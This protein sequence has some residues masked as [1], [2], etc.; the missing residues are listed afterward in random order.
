MD[1]YPDSQIEAYKQLVDQIDQV[2]QKRSIKRSIEFVSNGM[3]T[4]YDRVIDLLK[5]TN[6]MFSISYDPVGRYMTEQQKQRA[7][8]TFRYFR[9]RAVISEVSITLSKPAIDQYLKTDDLKYF[10]RVPIGVCFYLKTRDDLVVCDDD[11]YRFWSYVRERGY[12]NVTAYNQIVRQLVDNQGTG[13][14]CNCANRLFIRCGTRKVITTDCAGY[15]NGETAAT[16]WI[17]EVATDQQELK[18]HRKLQIKSDAIR[19]CA[20][21]DLSSNCPR[22]CANSVV[23]GNHEKIAN[24]YIRRLVEDIKNDRKTNSNHSVLSQAQ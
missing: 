18:A 13:R 16:N 24:C 8:R 11:L 3:F 10:D 14:Y 20:M 21:C 7:L 6:S 22:V 15:I 17:D 23:V 19:G 2:L 5:R 12:K 4:K 1:S 9:D